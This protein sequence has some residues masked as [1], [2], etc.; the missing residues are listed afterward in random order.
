MEEDLSAEMM[1]LAQSTKVTGHRGCLDPLT[2]KRWFSVWDL[3]GG[4][5]PQKQS[6][7]KVMQPLKRRQ[8][9]PFEMVPF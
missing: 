2:F 4:F 5:F 6:L 9:F 7:P 3:L 1:K 8:A